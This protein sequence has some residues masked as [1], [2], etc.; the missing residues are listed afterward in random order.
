MLFGKAGYTFN[1]EDGVYKYTDLIANNPDGL[2]LAEAKNLYLRNDTNIPLLT[3]NFGLN[4]EVEETFALPEMKDA[5]TTWR[6]NEGDKT[7]LPTT[8]APSLEDATEYGRI[9]T[10]LNTYSQEMMLKFIVG[11]TPFSEYDKYLAELD[12]RGLK[13]L[14]EIS[15]KSYDRYIAR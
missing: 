10:D 9:L 15:Q 6:N 11:E 14:I 7:R 8:L 5:V 4:A 2:T 1:I 3:S 13:R 12:K